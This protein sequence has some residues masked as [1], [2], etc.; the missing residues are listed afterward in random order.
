L[1][2][3]AR[4]LVAF[5][6]TVLGRG[7]SPS[8]VTVLKAETLATMLTARCTL[9]KHS[10]CNAFGVAFMLFDWSGRRIVGHD[11]S[12]MG[13]QAFLRIVPD[14]NAVV[15]LL[16]NGGFATELYYR[17]FSELFAQAFDIHMPLRP[18]PRTQ[19]MDPTAW[20]GM[21]RKFSQD[22]VV[23]QEQDE[24]IATVNGPR[25]GIP[26]QRFVLKPVNDSLCVG[27]TNASPTPATFHRVQDSTG[28]RY[29]LT[30]G[31]VHQRI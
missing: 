16:T 10:M 17:F 6:R 12:T 2:A 26:L 25:Y 18:T 19:P 23:Q 7:V 13:Q 27:T 22:V 24:L 9:P 29:L 15:A 1:Y 3:A 21:Y 30:G 11:G 14:A 31:R 28:Q 4:D 5:G 8:N 20:T